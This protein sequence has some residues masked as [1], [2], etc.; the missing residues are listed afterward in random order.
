MARTD[1]HRLTRKDL[2]QPDEF[3]TLTRQALRFVEEN[4]TAVMA[5]LGTLIVVLLAIVAYRMI[6]QSREASASAAYTE[7][8]ALL[9]AKKFGEAATQFDDV[10]NRYGGHQL[11][12]IGDPRARQRLDAGRSSR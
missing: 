8:R 3:Q 7:A 10:A 5:V 12:L 4:R 6:S 11:R 1:E 2:R 9:T